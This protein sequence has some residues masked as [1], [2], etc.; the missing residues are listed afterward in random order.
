MSEEKQSTDNEVLTSTS[1]RAR[2]H[3]LLRQANVRGLRLVAGTVLSIFLLWLAFRN[4]P[5]SQIFDAFSH[6]DWRFMGLAFGLTLAGTLARAAR[7]KLLYHPDHKTLNSLRMAE[8]LFI[9]QMLNIVVP[10]RLGEVAR[11]QMMSQLES[12]S[13]VLTLSTIVVEK[14]LDILALLIIMFLVPVSV[15]LPVWFQDS[16]KSLIVF[17]ITF[18][19]ATLLLSYGK[20]WLLAMLES[21]FHFLPQLW[22]TR[23]QQAAS[24]ALGSLDVLRSPWVG[25]QLQAW[26]LLIWA[27]GILVNYIVFLILGLSLPFVAALVLLVVLQ[28]G[29]A[30]PSVPGKLGIF[31]YLCILALAP[32][33]VGKSSALSYSVL[34]Y[35]VAVGPLL[36]LGAFFIW[37]EGIRGQRVNPPPHK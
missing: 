11:I 13:R 10:A 24:L 36:L 7:W 30:V 31:Q 6:L 22:R 35:L 33:G 15:S 32:F 9:S 28:L 12:R 5:V 27:M 21:T 19:G 29:F 14:W 37:W 1:W 17:A 25:L 2:T 34:L 8:A 26:S 4:V 23:F 16:R 18:F 20:S 3:V